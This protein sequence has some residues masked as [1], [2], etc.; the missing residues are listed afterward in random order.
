MCYDIKAQ[1]ETQLL[2]AERDG[3]AHAVEEIMERLVPLTDLPLHHSKGF[4]HPDIL[5]YTDEDPYFPKVSTWGLVPEDAQDKSFWNNTLNARGETV[6]KLPS[7]RDSAKKKRC[8][9]HCD[10]FYEHHHN[11]GAT[12]PFHIGKKDKQPLVFA[13][14]WSEWRDPEN[15]GLWNTFAIVTTEPNP[16]M[17]ILHNNPKAKFGPRMP[18]ILDE[19]SQEEWIMP[20]DEKN[21]ELQKKHLKG[22]LKPYPQEELEYYTVDRLRGKAYR[23]NVPQITDKFEYADFDVDYTKWVA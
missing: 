16:L 20:Y 1:L 6:F 14:I 8:I 17:S 23:G 19:S 7:F 4:D 5:I 13:G 12:Y 2:R 11:G 15:N 18:V 3:D 9:I 22:L 21:W 10:A